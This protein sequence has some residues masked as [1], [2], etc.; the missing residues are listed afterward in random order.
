M[1][2]RLGLFF[3]CHPHQ[4]LTGNFLNK[5]S[6]LC[7][8]YYSFLLVLQPIF[9]LLPLPLPPLTEVG[10]CHGDLHMSK[11]DLCFGDFLLYTYPQHLYYWLF[12]LKTHSRAFSDSHLSW[13]PSDPTCSSSNSFSSSSS[14]IQPLNAVGPHTSVLATLHANT[15]H[16]ADN[17]HEPVYDPRISIENQDLS[18]HLDY[19]VNLSWAH[20]SLECLTGTSN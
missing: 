9:W 8:S 11:C 7:N 10:P 3:F 4:P 20:I 19:K 12:P 13:V 16:V 1:P 2:H 5:L 14:C 18:K 6:T 17:N 15:F